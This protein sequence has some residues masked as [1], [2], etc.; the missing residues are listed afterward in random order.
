MR[1]PRP[2]SAA[3]GPTGRGPLA[4]VAAACGMEAVSSCG[5]SGGRGVWLKPEWRTFPPGI[6]RPGA[7]PSTSRAF[8]MRTSSIVAPSVVRA[9]VGRRR[10]SSKRG[11][12]CVAGRAL[13]GWWARLISGVFYRRA[14]RIFF[15]TFQIVYFL[16]N[17]GSV[18]S[19]KIKNCLRKQIRKH[20]STQISL[21]NEYSSPN[22]G[23]LNAG[24]GVY[25]KTFL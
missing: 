18:F 10:R 19:K 14:A 11:R 4:A 23:F 9:F 6:S 2:T 7:S 5:R 22:Y 8:S 20:S 3:L 24:V 16:E 21:E 17:F 15:G 1:V 12:L 13:S 25:G